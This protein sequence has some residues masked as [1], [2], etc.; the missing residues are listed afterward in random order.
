LVRTS[1]LER[2]CAPLCDAVLGA[3]V[4]SR[5]LDEL[6]RTNLF[7]L[8]LDDRRRWF[9][10]HHLFAQILGVELER[11]SPEQVGDLHRRAYEW[12]AEHGTTDEAIHH[13]VAAGAF[14]EAGALIAETWVTYANV[15]RTA[16]V[17]EWLSRI[18]SGAT[19]ARLLVVSAWVVGAP[20]REDEMRAAAHGCARSAA[21]T[22]APL[23]DGFASLE[24]SLSVLSATFGWGDVGAILEHGARSAELE[25]PDSPWRPVITWALGWAHYCQRRPRRGRALAEET[26]EIAP[27]AEQW[28][29]GVAAIAD[30]SLIAGMRGRRAEQLR[31]AEEAVTLT[32]RSGCSTRSRTARCTPL[33]R[34]ARAH[35]RAR[36]RSRTRE[37]RLPAPAVGA[38]ARPR[39]T[40]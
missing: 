29:V 26:T 17:A 32:A 33:R 27:P 3:P 31:L 4:S 16:S 2:L 12:H 10:F 13:A 25:G 5:A 24:S 35:G 15:G 14:A 21:S 20:R 28:I 22:T 9:R 30:L 6:A 1:V 7:L 39:S 8:P 23:P 40:G 11:R 36:R 19:D 18:P 34:R 37:G 38:A